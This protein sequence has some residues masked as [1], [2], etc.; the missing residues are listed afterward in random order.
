M[1]Q[2][3]REFKDF[4]ADQARL[5]EAQGRP[6]AR[7]QLTQGDLQLLIQ[8]EVS[9]EAMTGHPDFDRFLSYLQNAVVICE[10]K[11]AYLQTQ[12]N[13]PMVVNADE[14]MGIKAMLTD[15]NARKEAW[16]A[17]INLPKDIMENGENA[18][19]LIVDE[20]DA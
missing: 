19:E 13:D 4:Q 14:I 8:A 6:R 7:G 5:A 18:R 3:I 1:R 16:Q 11:I 17:A 2:D 20:S 10:Q 15:A 9:A 12:L